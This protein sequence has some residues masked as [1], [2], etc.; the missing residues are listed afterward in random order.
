MEEG[1][2]QEKE[3][4]TYL[5][6]AGPNSRTI[7]IIIIIAPFSSVFFD[8]L[9]IRTVGRFQRKHHRRWCNLQPWVHEHNFL[10]HFV[11]FCAGK[12]KLEKNRILKNGWKIRPKT[13]FPL[14]PLITR[15]EREQRRWKGMTANESTIG[16]G[17][18]ILCYTD[19]HF[20]LEISNDLWGIY[21]GKRSSF[22]TVKLGGENIKGGES[23]H[24]TFHVRIMP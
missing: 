1:W 3:V 24:K 15:R 23:G 4:Q 20:C 21:I 16:I 7:I 18:L 13:E 19:E 14:S 12:T 22:R 9:E 17:I 10:G 2:N 5:A 11:L 8:G 6:P